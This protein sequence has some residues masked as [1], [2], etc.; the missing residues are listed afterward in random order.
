VIQ[1]LYNRLER[2]A[3]A[4]VLPSC[5]RQNLGV[6]ARVPLASGYLTG[7]YRPGA[8]FPANDF[9]SSQKPEEVAEKL[10]EVEKI[11]REEVPAGVPL[12]RWALAWCLRHPAVTAVIPGCKS[13]EQVEENARAAELVG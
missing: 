3:E 2:K 1:V 4:G 10:R 12:A 9:R 5:Q 8:T 7:K 6:F 13:A 11:G